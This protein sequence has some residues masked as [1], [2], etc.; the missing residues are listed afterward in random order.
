M[1]Q[2]RPARLDKPSWR[3][4]LA[5]RL[6]RPAYRN[7]KI[8]RACRRAMGARE[9]ATTSELVRIAYVRRVLLHGKPLRPDQY[10]HVHRA[11]EQIGAVRIR[12]GGGRGRPWIWALKHG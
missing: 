2:N 1:A 11:M 8:Q 9:T 7:G 3:R 5:K 6:P 4:N 10:R 12:R